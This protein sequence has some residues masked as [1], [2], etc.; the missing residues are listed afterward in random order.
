MFPLPLP[1]EQPGVFGEQLGGMFPDMVSDDGGYDSRDERFERLREDGMSFGSLESQD[2]W[3][4]E[5]A[6]LT[7]PDVQQRDEEIQEKSCLTF[8]EVIQVLKA[9][10]ASWRA[11][12]AHV[13]WA[14]SMKINGDFRM[15]KSEADVRV[16][17]SDEVAEVAS[18]TQ[19]VAASTESCEVAK[20]LLGVYKFLRPVQ[21][22]G[23]R[24]LFLAYRAA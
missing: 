20:V 8:L 1:D 19:L 13:A 7:I 3:S 17:H 11:A 15:E 21:H 6:F 5:R 4:Q 23:E 14:G 22:L 10:V 2:E 16:F 12:G 18:I 24:A 9:S